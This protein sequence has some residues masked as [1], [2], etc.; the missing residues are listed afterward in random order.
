MTQALLEQMR[1]QLAEAFELIHDMANM[2]SRYNESN[3]AKQINDLHKV[4]D[5]MNALLA[6]ATCSNCGSGNIAF[7]QQQTPT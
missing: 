6:A 1:C 5:A 4:I 2:I 3:Q 7:T